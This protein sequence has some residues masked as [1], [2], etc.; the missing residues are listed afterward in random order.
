MN[1]Y[2]VKNYTQDKIQMMMEL[3]QI[4]T[5]NYKEYDHNEHMKWDNLRR[6]YGITKDTYMA[7]LEEQEWVCKI[8]K[9]PETAKHP[10]TKTLKRLSVDHCHTTGKVRGLL[11]TSCNVAVGH[12]E[13]LDWKKIDK[14]LNG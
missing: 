7:M 5:S 8:C 3:S 13:N 1:I 11:C 4:D 12:Y 14:Y 10:R 2:T 6:R 9:K